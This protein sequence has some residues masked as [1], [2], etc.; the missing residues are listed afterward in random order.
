MSAAPG[1]TLP[2]A[3]WLWVPGGRYVAALGARQFN[4]NTLEA[5]VVDSK[6]GAR[7]MRAPHYVLPLFAAG[8]SGGLTFS[9][10]GKRALVADHVDRYGIRGYPSQSN[11]L[12]LLEVPSGKRLARIDLPGRL[13]SVRWLPD[14][15]L[16]AIQCGRTLE[17]HAA[18]DGRLLSRFENAIVGEMPLSELSALP[19]GRAATLSRDGVLGTWDLARGVAD[20]VAH[21]WRVST[22]TP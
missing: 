10:D 16:F 19:G 21:D 4:G 11:Q 2:V 13:G 18:S 1:Q 14:A 7:A 3:T 17:A 12:A 5:I 20:P 15:P 8:L 22:T 9:P 6:T